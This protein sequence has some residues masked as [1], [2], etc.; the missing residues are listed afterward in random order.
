MDHHTQLPASEPQQSDLMMMMQRRRFA[1]WTLAGAVGLALSACGGGGG[2]GNHSGSERSLLD[3]F[4]KLRDGMGPDDVTELAGRTA[5]QIG[6]SGY[7]WS[8]E[9]E[10]LLTDFNHGSGTQLSGATWSGNGSQQ[11]TKS[12]KEV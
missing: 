2:D 1:H 3:V 7:N 12:F 11:R 8:N 6:G 4:N 10:I 9:S 5:N